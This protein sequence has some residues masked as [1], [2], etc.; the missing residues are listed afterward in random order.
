MYIIME[1]EGI[2]V[3]KDKEEFVSNNK[4]EWNLSEVFKELQQIRYTHQE[5]QVKTTSAKARKKTTKPTKKKTKVVMASEET[6]F[7]QNKK[8]VR[9]S[10]LIIILSVLILLIIAAFPKDVFSNESSIN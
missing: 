1:S 5:A 9:L 3:L 8:S 10:N 7:H 6:L 2:Y 4:D